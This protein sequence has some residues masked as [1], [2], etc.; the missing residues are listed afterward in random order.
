MDSVH[1]HL[2]LNHLPVLGG[3][4]GFLVLAWGVL[5]GYDEVKRVG[6]IV[7]VLT[8]FVAVPVYLTGE[9]AEEVAEHLPGVSEAIIEPHEDL[10]NFAFIAAIVSGVAALAAL[11]AFRFA[12]GAARVLTFA[13]LALSL[14]TSGLM[15]QT[16]NLGGQIRHSEIRQG[17]QNNAPANETQNKEKKK[18]ADEDDD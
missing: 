10:A 18:D 12:S 9:P 11:L 8:A 5:R 1:L 15:I 14:V 7:L 3:I 16:A 17:A 6:L 4:F 2:M 13:T